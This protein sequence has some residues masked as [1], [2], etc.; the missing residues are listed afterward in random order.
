MLR[1]SANLSTLFQ[2]VPLIERI[3][4]AADNG[5]D[6]VEIQFPYGKDAVALQKELEKWKLP[7]VLIN[8]PVGDL[9]DG[10][11]GLAAIPGLEGAFESALCEARETA[12]ILRP[13]AMNLLAG[14]PNAKHDGSDCQ[15]VFQSNLRKAY[16]LTRELKIQLVSEPVNTF[17]M[18]GFFLNKSQQALDLI[19]AMPDIDLRIQYDLY[20]IYRMGIDLMTDLP[21]T[22]DQV[23]HMQFSDFPGRTEPRGG[24]K[25]GQIFPLINALGYQGY[26]GAEYFPTTDT[27]DTL[28]W[29]RPYS[30]I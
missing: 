8:F 10:G 3:K 19:D 16:A 5:F 26:I 27:A 4:L 14:R 7:L 28:E 12:H 6:G 17:D 23:G 21:R 30:I 22:I 9:M 24:I 13:C 29:M 25:F 1:F 20:H 18:P 15:L 2:E 11:E